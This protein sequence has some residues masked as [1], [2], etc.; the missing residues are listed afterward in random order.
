M[1]LIICLWPFVL[2][3][4]IHTGDEYLNKHATHTLFFLKRLN[5]LLQQLG[6]AVTANV[7]QRIKCVFCREYF[8]TTMGSNDD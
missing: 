8:E 2:I 6:M 4:V 3:P 5:N 1:H 7:P